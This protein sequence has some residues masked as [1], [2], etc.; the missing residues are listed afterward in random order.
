MYIQYIDG[1]NI[2]IKFDFKRKIPVFRRLVN[3]KQNNYKFYEKL[4]NYQNKL[5]T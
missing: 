4:V 1:L 3:E 5:R 2:K